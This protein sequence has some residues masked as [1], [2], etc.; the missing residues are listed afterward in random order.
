MMRSSGSCM[1]S[2]SLPSLSTRTSQSGMGFFK[3]D[4]SQCD[5]SRKS[6]VAGQHA[7]DDFASDELLNI[8]LSETDTITLLDMPSTCMSEE[9]ENAQAVKESNNIYLELCQNRLGND[10]YVERAMQTFVGAAKHK[11]V[12]SD[13]I[14]M[15]D[16]GTQ[17]TIWD[18]HDSFQPEVPKE[19]KAADCMVEFDQGPKR[20]SSSSSISTIGTA[21]TG[22]SLFAF[23]MQGGD[24]KDEPELQQIFKS[25]MFQSN[26]VIMERCLVANIFQPQLATY[27][28]LPEIK[29]PPPV[30][31]P[32]PVVLV[33]EEREDEEE[34]EEQAVVVEPVTEVK[35]EKQV[36]EKEIKEEKEEEE[37]KVEEEVL[38][39]EAP[40]PFLELLW[41]FSC[42]LTKGRNITCMAWNKQNTDLLAVGYG[43]FKPGKTG[44]ICCWSIKNLSWPER[45]YNCHSGITSLDFSSTKPDKLAVGM[46]DGTVAIF[47]VRN[48]ENR[49]FLTSSIDCKKRHVHP[50][51][52]ITWAKQ[53][54]SISDED[55]V[56]S[57][58]S[59]SEDGRVLKWLL[60]SHGLDGLDMLELRRIQDGIKKAEGNKTRKEGI[61]VST[62]TPG[63]CLDFQ[64]RD[65]TIYLAG[66]SEGVVHKCS[67]SNHHHYLALYQK[68]LCPVNRVQWSPFSNDVFL[69][70]SADWT[71]QLWK[72]DCL[73]PAIGFTS[74]QSPVLSVRWSPL[75][76]SVFAAVKSEQL[77]IWDLNASLMDPVIVE[78]A[79]QGIKL[80]SMLFAKGSD[81]ILVGNSVGQVNFYRI[82]N[83]S[84]GPGK[85]VPSLE[86]LVHF[87]TGN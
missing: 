73:T 11:K 5:S 82:S 28:K 59:I 16:Q 29:V 47:S 72:E 38:E 24:L 62:A 76:P 30:M 66:T 41:M 2:S 13:K 31:E 50:V 58:V 87:P 33:E 55:T 12:Q 1:W 54:M 49:T 63:L 52:H 80:T 56:E 8:Y 86:E 57:V 70:C 36:T 77:E 61:L 32:E 42:E 60:C 45:I 43:D 69:S 15:H 3:L 17:A 4:T 75:W 19:E 65:P 22:S 83:L 6:S 51:W 81:C 78:P 18:I 21:S 74:I 40:N 7:A 23:K 39:E 14:L 48:R 46:Y 68:H 9:A 34:D 84:V 26:L 37:E 71:I 64:P 79:A 53:E 27:R 35:Q 44:L 85:K 25:D 10:K 20:T 67:V